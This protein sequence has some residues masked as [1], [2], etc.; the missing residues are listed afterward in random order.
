[1]KK[2]LL[3]CSLLLLTGC[4]AKAETTTTEAT[5]QTSTEVITEA[6]TEATTET[7][8]QE[9]TEETYDIYDKDNL[10]VSMII[11][12]NSLSF[13]F[14]NNSDV[15]LTFEVPRIA[16]NRLY[17]KDSTYYYAVVPAHSHA[18]TTDTFDVVTIATLNFRLTA[19]DDD[20]N[21]YINEVNNWEI[22]SGKK[23][24]AEGE[25]I[26]TQNQVEFYYKER[27]GNQFVFDVFNRGTEP[28]D[29]NA[30]NIVING[31]AM[32]D[33]YSMD[34]FVVDLY[35]GCVFEMII[36]CN[37]ND[38]MTENGISDVNELRFNCFGLDDN[39]ND[40]QTETITIKE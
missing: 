24:K 30:E 10:Y 31:Y 8:T 22:G 32:G 4:G 33:C 15:N 28:I 17:S 6:T 18:I 34:S 7:T 2:L 26:T 25:L 39:L 12:G 37:Y 9:A 40:W 35:G 11:K 29:I 38:F 27:R 13:Y 3:C 1:M 21:D 19:F 14:E 23:Y 5:T 36:D 16:M 20:F